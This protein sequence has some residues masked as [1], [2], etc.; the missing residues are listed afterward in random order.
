MCKSDLAQ[1]EEGDMDWILDQSLVD[2]GIETVVIGV[3]KQVD[4]QAPL[5]TDFLSKK[6]E[7]EAWTLN[8]DLSSVK[9]EAV[10][11]GYMDLLKEVGRSVKKNPPTILALIKN[12][13]SRGFLPTIN[14]VIDIYNVECLRSFLAIGGHD[15]DK[16]QGPIEFTVSQKEDIFLPILST[17][18]KVSETDPV[19]RDCQ[20]VLAWLDVRDSEHYKFEDQTRNAI[21]IIQGNRE[22]SVAMRLEALERIHQ[23]LTSCM[24]NVRFEKLLV[25]TSGTTQVL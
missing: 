19:Y 16:I 4:P 17:E 15:L 2:L 5:S 12:I 6:K 25:T 10:V 20:G 3:A 8:C 23:D 7:M 24:P 21:F 11:Q 13:Q 1:K 9:E 22:T 14:S 18:K